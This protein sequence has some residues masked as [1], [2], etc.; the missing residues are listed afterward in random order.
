LQGLLVQV[1]H[2]YRVKMEQIMLTRYYEEDDVTVFW[3]SINKWIYV[4]WKNMPSKQTVIEGCK[5]ILKLLVSKNASVVLNDNRKITGTWVLASRW[6]AEEWFPQIIASGLNKF[7]W[8]ESQNS[9]LSVISAKRSA[10]KYT[11]IIKLFKDSS[12]AESWLRQEL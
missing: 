9:S 8:I 1:F 5:R 2:S 7:A 11:N 4:D 3:D 6:V 12:E 10:K